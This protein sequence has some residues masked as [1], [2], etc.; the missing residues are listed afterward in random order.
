MSINIDVM[1]QSH[2]ELPYYRP[3]ELN[4]NDNHFN[5]MVTKIQ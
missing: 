5:Q 4:V 3:D 2:I 1:Q